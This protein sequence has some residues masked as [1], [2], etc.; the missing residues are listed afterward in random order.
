MKIAFDVDGI[1][2]KLQEFEIKYGRQFFDNQDRAVDIKELGFKEIF[3]CSEEE[4]DKFWK[5]YI[6]RYC[7]L[8]KAREDASIVMN[9]LKED[10]DE[11][12]ILTARAHTTE[13]NITGKLFR[14]ML[15]YFLHKENIPYDHIFYYDEETSAL[16]KAN[17]CIDE[18]I[19]FIMD[20]Q[21]KNINCLKTVTNVCYFEEE[22]N[23]HC[24]DD[25]VDNVYK[26][27]NFSDFYR[28]INEYKKRSYKE[29]NRGGING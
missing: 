29:F 6:W 8:E 7:L 12:Y 26:V 14:G 4:E 15:I 10:G 20:D 17:T 25:N 18:G 3:K 28:V 23:K 5:K 22:H 9:K 24:E 11:I 19:E 1:L 21:S 2:T 13:Q 16:E 27:E